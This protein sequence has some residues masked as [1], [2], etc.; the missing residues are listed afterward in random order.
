MASEASDQ[1]E[2]LRGTPDMLIL[3]ALLLGPAHGHQVAKHIQRTIDDLLQVEHGSLDPALRRLERRGLASSNWERAK[4][5]NRE[6][7]IAGSPRRAGSSLPPRS[8]NGSS[9][10]ARSRG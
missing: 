10:L 9:W 8:R 4:D 2:L 6:F 5:R 3:R 7:N 1:I